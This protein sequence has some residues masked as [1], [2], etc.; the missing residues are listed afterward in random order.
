MDTLYPQAKQLAEKILKDNF[1]ALPPVRIDEVAKNYGLI[2]VEADL[3]HSSAISG[4]IDIKNKRVVL[5]KYDIEPRK[6]YTIAHELG[7]Y[8]MHKDKL[9]QDPDKYAI[10]YRK[11]IGTEHDPIEEE[12]SCFAA[13]LLVPDALLTHYKDYDNNTMAKIFGVPVDVIGLRT[14]GGIYGTTS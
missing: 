3:D 10:F 9:E 11:P 2:V 6:A 8:L 5:N 7:H 12:A 14:R 4:F 1:I 13:H